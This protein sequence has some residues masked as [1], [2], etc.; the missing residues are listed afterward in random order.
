MK[1]KRIPPNQWSNKKEA[2][3]KWF[4][5]EVDKIK[6]SHL[7]MERRVIEARINFAKRI[8]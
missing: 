2:N 8:I 4:R 7:G 1:P 5:E 6:Q 3:E